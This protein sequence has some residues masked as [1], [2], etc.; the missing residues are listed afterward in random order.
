MDVLERVVG[1]LDLEDCLRLRK[2]SRNLRTLVDASE[3]H[4]D[5]V[6]FQFGISTSVI[7]FEYADVNYRKHD[8]ERPVYSQ[9]VYF[10]HNRHGKVN[11]HDDS[12]NVQQAMVADASTFLQN[13][14]LKI[15]RLSFVHDW[16]DDDS[17][18]S[19][20][21]FVKFLKSLNFQLNARSVE[22]NAEEEVS[23]SLL[24]FLKPKC[25]EEVRFYGYRA[26]VVTAE[27]LNKHVETEQWKGARKLYCNYLPGSVQIEH[28]LHFKEI[29]IDRLQFSEENLIMVRDLLLRSTHIEFGYFGMKD[30]GGSGYEC[31]LDRIFGENDDDVAQFNE[32]FIP[33]SHHYFRLD[34]KSN[35]SI[36][37]YAWTVKKMWAT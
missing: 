28:L 32:F 21:E 8:N 5:E 24:Q 17:D 23:F 14:R 20:F 16:G 19:N 2:V 31:L 22:I 27:Q 34:L 6:G 26:A 35:G 33:N 30:P 18:A 13:P 25:L 12:L 37:A 7:K 4:C 1:K 36:G 9:K 11:E 29:R 3:I 15:D 10:R